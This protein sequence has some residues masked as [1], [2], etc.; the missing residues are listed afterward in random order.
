MLN[1]HNFFERTWEWINHFVERLTVGQTAAIGG[2]G[3]FASVSSVFSSEHVMFGMQILTVGLGCLG[4]LMSVGLLTLKFIQQRR[5]MNHWT[6]K[7]DEA[8]P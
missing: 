7:K 8:K 4:A 3:S 5:E 1:L 6:Q 2:T